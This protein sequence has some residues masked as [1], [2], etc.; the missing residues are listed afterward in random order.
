MYVIRYGKPFKTSE[1]IDIDL[2]DKFNGLYPDK[3][4]KPNTCLAS[5]FADQDFIRFV[6]SEI[7]SGYKLKS[8]SLL[9]IIEYDENK[10]HPI[11]VELTGED[12]VN[13][14]DFENA[15]IWSNA[16]GVPEYQSLCKSYW[17][18]YDPE[19]IESIQTNR[20]PHNKLELNIKSTRYMFDGIPNK[21]IPQDFYHVETTEKFDWLVK[22]TQKHLYGDINL[23]KIIKSSII[24][25]G[26]KRQ[27]IKKKEESEF[28]TSFAKIDPTKKYISFGI[29]LEYYN[30]TSIKSV[31]NTPD[32]KPKGGLWACEYFSTPYKHSEWEQF[33]REEKY[34]TEED[35]LKKAIKF[36]INEQSK[37]L[38]LETRDDVDHLILKFGMVKGNNPTIDFERISKSYD[39]VIISADAQFLLD[40]YDLINSNAR[41]KP[42]CVP[43]IIVFSKSILRNVEDYD[44]ELENISTSMITPTSALKN[45]LPGTTMAKIN[46]VKAIEKKIRQGE[47]VHGEQ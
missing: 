6:L 26:K 30:S 13:L 9:E 40:H 10:G 46:E 43:G 7:H 14:F 8:N 18:L 35:Y 36:S 37:L 5:T 34:L 22:L 16:P 2:L 24:L 28:K 33:C 27:D 29:T 25:E 11:L 21:E 17:Y 39:G 32:I 4:I 12:D 20:T 47:I 41:P 23:N 38:R 3:K 15:L 42:F 44:Y 45:A 31:E 19:Y 1:T